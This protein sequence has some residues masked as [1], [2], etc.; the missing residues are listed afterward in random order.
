MAP[1]LRQ[2]ARGT[3]WTWP[4]CLAPRCW[5]CLAQVVWSQRT[6]RWWFGHPMVIHFAHDQ[7]IYIYTYEEWRV[8]ESLRVTEACTW[9][10]IFMMYVDTV[11]RCLEVCG[12]TSDFG[13]FV[14][15]TSWVFLSEN[16]VRSSADLEMWWQRS[17][18]RR[19]LDPGFPGWSMTDT[20]S[21]FLRRLEI[22]WNHQWCTFYQILWMY[23]WTPTD[24]SFK[25]GRQ[26]T[27]CS[28]QSSIGCGLMTS[29][30]TRNLWRAKSQAWPQSKQISVDSLAAQQLWIVMRHD[31]SPKTDRYAQLFLD[32]LQ[33]FCSFLQLCRM[34]VS[35]NSFSDLSFGGWISPLV[36][37]MWS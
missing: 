32:G 20:V 15:E 2:L 24:C 8:W 19:Q 18:G 11:Q 4:I 25:K 16:P 12:P 13:T 21:I 1:F 6:D 10:T 33:S 27:V 17:S 14:S 30:R 7:L 23:L 22:C 37:R 26:T 3:A 36:R 5:M 35:W 28:M 29:T 31:K 34:L 9:T